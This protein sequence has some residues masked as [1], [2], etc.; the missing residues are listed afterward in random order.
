MTNQPGYQS[1]SDAWEQQSIP[2][3]MPPPQQQPINPYGEWA[4]EKTGLTG[5]QHSTYN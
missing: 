1:E 4:D 5:T 2:I 3:A